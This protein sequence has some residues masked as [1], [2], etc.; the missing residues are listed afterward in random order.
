[1]AEISM[2]DLVIPPT[3]PPAV[4]WCVKCPEETG[5][6]RYIFEGSGLCEKHFKEKK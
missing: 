5:Y 3:L 4:G 2:D 6:A 1:M